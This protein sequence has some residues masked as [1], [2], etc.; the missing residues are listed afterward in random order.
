MEIILMRHGHPV[1]L[2][3]GL[4]A[5]FEMERWIEDY[6]RSDVEPDNIP[7]ASAQAASCASVI[8][9]STASRALSSVQALGY[10]AA[11]SDKVLC[12]AQLPF[13][14]WRFPYLP[15]QVWAA[16]F[17]VSWLPGYSRGAD[18][19]EATKTR[20]RAGAQSTSVYRYPVS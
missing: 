1:L 4:P 17:R 9:V 11:V 8:V 7:A 20:A 14:L 19:F 10:R 15:L 6:N 5:P 16:L 18:S 3:S 12:E 13:L 2:K